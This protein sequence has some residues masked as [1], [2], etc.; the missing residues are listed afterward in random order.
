MTRRLERPQLTGGGPAAAIAE[1][2]SSL[3]PRR[4]LVAAFEN[5]T[6]DPSL[7]AVGHIA[8]DWI[9]QA[10]AGVAGIEVVPTMAALGSLKY[11][12]GLAG[13][14]KVVDPIRVLADDTGAGTIVYG[15][16]Y[17]QA[18]SLVY[19]ACVADATRA[20]IARAVG[21]V[22]VPR[23]SPIAAI[24]QVT[25]RI[26]TELAVLLNAGVSHTRAARPP[27]YPAYRAYVQAL[28]LFIAGAWREALGHLRRAARTD[29][30][31]TL[32]LIVS[33]IA[34]WNLGELAQAGAVARRASRSRHLLGP[35]EEA[36]L[37]TVLAWLR[38]DWSAAHE[39]VSRQARLAPDSI[40]HFQ[41]AE[42][43]RRLAE[44]DRL[45]ERLA[46][47]SSRR[48]AP[49]AGHHAHLQ[50]DLDLGYRGAIAA[51][52][53]NRPRASRVAARLERLDERY[54]F[55]GHTYWRASIAALQGDAEQ[56]ARLLRQAF[57]GGLPFDLFIHADPN[58][59]RVRTTRL[60]QDVIAPRG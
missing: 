21:P 8:A 6:G 3:N 31:F 5:R 41:V 24:E 37:D 44:A 52:R 45:F 12:R 55:G 33:A 48:P 1:T 42:E 15:S 29:P 54:S 49:P 32:P 2:T 19:S 7:D 58:F 28:D 59:E 13:E 26:V 18:D 43:A 35:F 39:A 9:A 46:R 60:F 51:R 27:A 23:G 16:Y 38:G 57:S 17:V 4:V 20:A 25:A 11:V 30:A 47:E 34:H 50:A 22:E 56:A 53:R 10:L 40:P 14:G 36:V